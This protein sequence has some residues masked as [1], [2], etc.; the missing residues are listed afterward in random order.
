MFSLKK[1]G[2]S[3]AAKL[4]LPLPLK[5]CMRRFRILSVWKLKS[6]VHFYFFAFVS[7]RKSSERWVLKSP[8][9]YFTH[10]KFARSETTSEL[11]H[12][13]SARAIPV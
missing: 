8:A 2:I 9:T 5:S 1:A 6:N 12:T 4:S 11:N 13:D 10:S 7:Q 3:L